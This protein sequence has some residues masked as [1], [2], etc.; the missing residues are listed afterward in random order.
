MGSTQSVSRQLTATLSRFPGLKADAGVWRLP[1]ADHVAR[2]LARIL[3][4]DQPAAAVESAAELMSVDPA[5]TLWLACA[6]GPCQASR[7]RCV[8]ELAAWFV[9]HGLSALRWSDTDRG[10]VKSPLVTRG[11]TRDH[12]ARWRDLTIN[13]VAVAAIA[14]DLA[15]DDLMAAE[16]FLLGLLH[17]A[18]DWLRTCG[19]RVLISDVSIS[20]LPGW[21]CELLKQR[22]KLPR[23]DAVENV[24]QAVTRWR[25]ADQKNVCL[26]DVNLDDV[27]RV[28]RWWQASAMS[29]VG[30][31]APLLPALVEKLLRL[32]QLENQFQQTLEREKL[33][34]LGEL[35]YGASHEINNPLANISTRAQTLLRDETDLERRR[36]LVVINTQAF[37]ANEMIADMMLF[38]RPPQLHKEPGDLVA[39]VQ[40]VID[41]L[42]PEADLQGTQLTLTG[43]TGQLI[44]PVDAAHLSVAVRA[45]CL[46]A[47]QALQG[48]GE[49]DVQVDVQTDPAGHPGT[50]NRIQVRDTGPGISPEARRHLFDPFFSGRE[51]GRGLGLGLSKC[52]RIVTDHGGHIEVNSELGHGTTISLYLPS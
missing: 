1:L 51:A 17:N 6:A 8:S 29:S 10:G 50:W 12:R 21:L 41:E 45:V 49:V 14:S 40:H 33:A 38:A 24:A 22:A 42:K 7:P 23:E 19:P 46:N 28:R 43:A 9:Q 34:A 4:M 3:V 44:G 18:V 27:R 16:S 48:G 2:E 47:L 5:F 11:K 31:T 25:Q 15:G 35:A 20:C 26:D 37:R 36:T 13:G 30:P 52:W 32:E 39:A